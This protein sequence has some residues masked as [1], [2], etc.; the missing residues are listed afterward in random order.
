M[1]C[2][3]NKIDSVNWYLIIIFFLFLRMLI[4]W[5][6]IHFGRKTFPEIS[7]SAL[8][9]LSFISFCAFCCHENVIMA[10][11]LDWIVLFK[12]WKELVYCG[13]YMIYFGVWWHH[14]SSTL[15][16]FWFFAVK[17]LTE[18]HSDDFVVPLG[19]F[20]VAESVVNQNIHN[21]TGLVINLSFKCLFTVNFSTYHIYD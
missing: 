19:S 8:H 6:R 16:I 2:L 12:I 14:L 4:S 7:L 21:Y 9:S 11:S 18:L 1:K 17:Q 15:R 3:Y 10:F 13:G 20:S 5:V